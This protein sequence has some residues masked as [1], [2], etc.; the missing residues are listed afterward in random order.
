MKAHI[1]EKLFFFILTI[2][3]GMVGYS[4]KEIVSDVK[5]SRLD[6]TRQDQVITNI[7]ERYESIN[8]IMRDH[9]NRI[10]IIEHEKNN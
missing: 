6:N 8:F 9:E 5:Q 4:I 2:T 1:W 7:I 10:R 3:I